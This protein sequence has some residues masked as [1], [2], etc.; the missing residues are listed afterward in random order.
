MSD[1]QAPANL[2]EQLVRELAN[3]GATVTF[4]L[5]NDVYLKDMP[6]LDLKSL[7]QRTASA[8]QHIS[9]FRRDRVSWENI[10]ELMPEVLLFAQ[11]HP[12]VRE[13]Y[14]DRVTNASGR[15]FDFTSVIAAV[16]AC[17]PEQRKILFKEEIEKDFGALEFLESSALAGLKKDAERWAYIRNFWLDVF[18]KWIE[19]TR[20]FGLGGHTVEDLVDKELAREARVKIAAAEPI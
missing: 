15:P 4:D 10:A 8:V 3:S 7:V 18:V 20:A 6:Q 17:S 5:M 13:A 16:R 14:S 1:G 9:H 11:L 12:I 2:V 19:D